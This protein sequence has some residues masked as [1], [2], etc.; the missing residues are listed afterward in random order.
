MKN[1]LT[2]VAVLELG[3]VSFVLLALAGSMA[4]PRIDSAPA[5]AAAPAAEQYHVQ[6]A[7]SPQ[8]G[9]EEP[10]EVRMARYEALGD[11]LAQGR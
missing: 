5:P 9:P 11:L 8:C 1:L 10:L 6:G 3:G 7:D 2:F 4:R